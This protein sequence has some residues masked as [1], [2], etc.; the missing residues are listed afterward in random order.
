MRSSC[1]IMSESRCTFAM[2][3]AAETDAQSRSALTR[4]TTCALPPSAG[5]SQSKWPS[6]MIVLS[7][8]GIPAL[9]SDSSAR[10]P[11]SPRH[12]VIPS[13]S[14]SS[15]EASPTALCSPQ[16]CARG[17]S[18]SRR[19]SL[20]SLESRRP[21]GIFGMRPLTTHMPTPTGPAIAPRPTSSTPMTK[22][23]PAR[24]K[25][26]SIVRVGV[27][28]VMSARALRFVDAFENVGVVVEPL[29]AVGWPADHD[30]APHDI[31]KR[32]ETL[33]RP[34]GVT[35]RVAGVVAVVAHHPQGAVRNRDGEVIFRDLRYALRKLQVGLIERDAIDGHLAEG[36]AARNLVAWEADD[37]L[38][39]VVVAVG[40][41]QADGREHP[42]D[43]L[44]HRGAFLLGRWCEP[45]ARVLEDDDV[46]PVELDDVGNELVDDDPVVDLERV[47]H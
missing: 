41:A 39:E 36:V 10:A 31:F 42:V 2:T 19:R 11:A 9:S 25:R 3:D 35:A 46:A 8:S 43:R 32:H 6:R 38:D 24:C 4:V 45:S 47:L 28:T 33:A 18:C 14:T 12:A 5:L 7:A 40:S 15:G 29:P 27:G 44:D 17:A 37:S 16:D 23:E 1:W 30:G 13:R 20:R 21:S 34:R 22:R 26:R